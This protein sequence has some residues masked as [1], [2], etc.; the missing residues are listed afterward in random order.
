MRSFSRVSSSSSLALVEPRAEPLDVGRPAVAVADRV[1]LE[2]VVG[3]A[4]IA[5]QRVVEMEHLGVERGV[6]GADRLDRELPV[7]AIA[8]ATGRP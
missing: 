8:P 1:Q 4:E 5:E 2:L 7:L 3:D 6:V